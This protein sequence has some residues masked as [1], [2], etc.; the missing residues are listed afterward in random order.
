MG[1]GGYLGPDYTAEYL[2][3]SSEHINDGSPRVR[4]AG[5][6]RARRSRC[7]GEPVRRAAGELEFTDEQV[8]AFESI[9]EYYADFFG[10]TSPKYGLIP[11]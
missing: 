8:A 2:R 10:E 7:F 11:R 6:L 3:R 9:R 1:H 4:P 5:P